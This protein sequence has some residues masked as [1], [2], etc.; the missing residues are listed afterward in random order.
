[1]DWI[2]LDRK[3]YNSICKEINYLE[4]KNRPSRLYQEV[5]KI[6]CTLESKVKFIL[7]HW[8]WD[9][10]TRDEGKL[11]V[12]QINSFRLT[13]TSETKE[14]FHQIY[15][16]SLPIKKARGLGADKDIYGGVLRFKYSENGWKDL[17]IASKCLSLKFCD[18]VVPIGYM[19]N[20]N[21]FS[22]SGQQIDGWE[23]P[24]YESSGAWT[25][26]LYLGNSGRIYFWDTE[27]S[28]TIGIEADSLLSFF[29]IAFG[30]ILDTEKIYGY[31]TEEDFA[32]MDEIERLWDKGIWKT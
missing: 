4:I 9:G 28:D 11:I 1:M 14:F 8:G 23:D 30:L 16:L 13:L 25:Y 24:N 7:Q 12:S 2:P 17:F 10:T 32:L 6:P 27:N 29:A 5:S 20:Y 18:D 3:E 15:G 31:T 26:E 21:G 19:L 22:S